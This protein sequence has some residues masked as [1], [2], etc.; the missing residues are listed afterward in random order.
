MSTFVVKRN[1][2]NIEDILRE[3]TESIDEILQYP[4]TPNY[5]IPRSKA[6]IVL[7]IKRYKEIQKALETL[8]SVA[9]WAQTKL[10]GWEFTIEQGFEDVNGIPCPYVKI[11]LR[12][13]KT[14]V[15]LLNI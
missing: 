9:R 10:R 3:N 12:W 11:V 15:K 5:K 1:F 7:R 14:R 8:E 2:K 6:P 4:E 13:D